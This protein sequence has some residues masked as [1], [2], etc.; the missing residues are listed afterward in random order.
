MCRLIHNDDLFFD[1]ITGERKTIDID[2]KRPY[3][4]GIWALRGYEMVIDS[5]GEYLGY[6]I[7]GNFTLPGE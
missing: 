2:D 5:R 4:N 1:S 7:N 3:T 6:M